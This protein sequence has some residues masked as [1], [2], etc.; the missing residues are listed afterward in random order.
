MGRKWLLSQ[1][2]APKLYAAAAAIEQSKGELRCRQWK[3]EGISLEQG[4]LAATEPSSV[5]NAVL[6]A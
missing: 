5:P 4:G 2:A 6:E 3:L 1:V